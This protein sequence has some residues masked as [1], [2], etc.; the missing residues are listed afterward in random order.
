MDF[1][2]PMRAAQLRAAVKAAASRLRALDAPNQEDRP[3]GKWSARQIVGHLVDSAIN[4][5]ARLIL[6][7]LQDDAIILGYAQ[8]SWVRLGRYQDAEWNELVSLWE[9]L[10]LQLARVIEAIP[11]DAWMRTLPGASI[12]LG[13]LVDDYLRHLTHHL[14]QILAD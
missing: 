6:G 2:C 10:N 3:P 4:N 9:L 13:G 7:Q 11:G 8:E 1:D 14:G 5:Y 12:T